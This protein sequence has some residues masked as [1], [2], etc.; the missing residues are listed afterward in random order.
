MQINYKEEKIILT[1]MLLLDYGLLGQII[2]S[3]PDQT[4]QFGRK[5]ETVV[6]NT[7]ATI[8]RDFLTRKINK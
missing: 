4:D 6:L 5:I 3:D 2:F 8:R 7:F 1:L